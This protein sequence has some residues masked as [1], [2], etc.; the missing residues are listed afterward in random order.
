ME[1]RE[2]HNST[3]FIDLKSDLQERARKWQVLQ[4]MHDAKVKAGR[5]KLH[6]TSKKCAKCGPRESIIR[7]TTG[8]GVPVLSFC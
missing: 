4:E 5:K 2:S 6:P 1:E 8:S 7:I 3:G